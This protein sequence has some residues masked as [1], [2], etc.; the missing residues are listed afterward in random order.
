M[1]CLN[2]WFREPGG[3]EIGF[4]NGQPEMGSQRGVSRWAEGRRGLGRKL[5]MTK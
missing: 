4:G 3:F 1:F 5:V 2:Q